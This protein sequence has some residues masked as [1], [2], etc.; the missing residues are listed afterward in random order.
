VPGEILYDSADG[1]AT[2]TLSNPG[3]LN[4]DTR[5]YADGLGAFLEK[6]APRFDAC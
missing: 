6:R 3:K 1:I 4:P 5:D 2:L